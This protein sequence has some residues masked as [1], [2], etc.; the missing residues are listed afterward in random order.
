MRFV[1]DENEI[2]EAGQ[3]V[4][5][6]LPDLLSET[7]NTGRASPAHLGIDLRD[8]EDVDCRREKLPAARDLAL[9]VFSGGDDWR[10]DRELSNALQHIF[11]RVRREVRD[12]L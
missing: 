7:T 11:R 4:E 6:A 9:V 8:V 5:I 2:V 10:R 12:Q 1:H 3:I